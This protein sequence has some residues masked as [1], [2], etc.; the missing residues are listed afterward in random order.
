VVTMLV[1]FILFR[2]RGYGCI[3]HPAFPCALLG[4][5]VQRLGRIAPRECGVA[6]VVIARSKATKQSIL[7]CL[8][9]GLLRFAR[10]DGSTQGGSG[11]R[12]PPF[13]ADKV[14]GYAFG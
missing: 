3:G 5:T 11:L 9:Y 13:L 1:C 7:S 8:P 6:F 4:G 2:T 14:V 12:N 10:N